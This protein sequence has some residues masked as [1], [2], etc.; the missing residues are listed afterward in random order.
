MNRLL[1]LASSLSLPSFLPPSFPPSHPPSL[2]NIS[3]DR[4]MDRLLGQ[5]VLDQLYTSKEAHAALPKILKSQCP[6][7]FT[8]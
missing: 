4:L 7:A 2:T 1:G 3:D 5:T 8:I 6:S